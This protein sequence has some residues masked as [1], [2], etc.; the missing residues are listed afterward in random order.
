MRPVNYSS[1]LFPARTK[2]R[3]RQVLYNVEIGTSDD[4]STYFQ[5]DIIHMVKQLQYTINNID[6][7]DI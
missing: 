5:C 1:S 4:F 2:S 7:Y 6:V 3:W